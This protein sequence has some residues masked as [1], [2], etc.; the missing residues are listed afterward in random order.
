[1]HSSLKMLKY[2]HTIT[3]WW[4]RQVSVPGETFSKSRPFLSPTQL[5]IQCVPEIQNEWRYTSSLLHTFMALTV[6]TV[7]QFSV[8]IKTLPDCL[9]QLDPVPIWLR[10]RTFVAVLAENQVFQCNTLTRAPNTNRASPK[11]AVEC[12]ISRNVNLSQ[13]CPYGVFF[14]W[15][16]MAGCGSCEHS[17]IRVDGV[18]RL[19]AW[20]RKCEYMKRF[21]DERSHFARKTQVQM[22][23]RS[24]YLTAVERNLHNV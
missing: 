19:V 9:A 6:P 17:L 13:H 23:S 18:S 14:F 8:S 7:L 10:A 21:I 1:M 24:S 11:K 3:Y 16:T 15:T 12:R 4:L 22:H 5:S 2:E 20:V